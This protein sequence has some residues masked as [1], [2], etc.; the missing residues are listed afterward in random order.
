[1]VCLSTVETEF[2]VIVKVVEDL[3]WVLNFLAELDFPQ[4][5][6]SH[7]HEDNQVYVEMVVNQSRDY[8]T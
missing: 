5:E 4:H 1:M 8:H 6:P 3:L 7:L 2:I